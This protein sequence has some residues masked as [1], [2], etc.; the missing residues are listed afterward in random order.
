MR[1]WKSYNDQLVKRG[2]LLISLD[3]LENWDLELERMNSG[4]RGRA[5]VYPQSLVKFLASVRVFFGL[6]YRQDEGFREGS[7]QAF[8]R[9]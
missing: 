9:A 2:E 7:F 4:K 3:L 5:F 8:A 6:S 1:D